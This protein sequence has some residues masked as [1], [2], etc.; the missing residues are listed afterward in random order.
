MKQL[1]PITDFF[2]PEQILR[3]PLF[4]TK[5]TQ[6]DK[7]KDVSSILIYKFNAISIKIPTNLKPKQADAK[8]YMKK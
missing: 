7:D 2:T 4:L 8:A 3:H 6:Q 1:R 5:T